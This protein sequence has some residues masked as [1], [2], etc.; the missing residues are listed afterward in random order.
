M[1][2]SNRS[3]KVQKFVPFDLR[4]M[5]DCNIVGGN[6]IEVP[7]GKYKKMSKPLSYC[8]LEFDCLYPLYDTFI[9]TPSSFCH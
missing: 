5:I 3:I 8:Q 1:R 4:F 2:E 9:I 7:C 6:W